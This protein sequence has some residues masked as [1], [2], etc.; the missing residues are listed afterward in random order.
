MPTE[1][2]RDLFWETDLEDIQRTYL[3]KG[4]KITDLPPFIDD[5]VPSQGSVFIALRR[6]VNVDTYRRYKK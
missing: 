5:R 3:K 2:K 6:L 1:K 4:Q